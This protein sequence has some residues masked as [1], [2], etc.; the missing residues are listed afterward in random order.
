MC[1]FTYAYFQ[2]QRYF[3]CELYM[4]FM[5]IEPKDDVIV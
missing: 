3:H 4:L 5:Q 1:I 2:P